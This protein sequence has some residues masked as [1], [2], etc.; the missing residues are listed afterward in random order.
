MEFFG[1]V[2][3]GYLLSLDVG[4]QVIGY[5]PYYIAPDELYELHLGHYRVPLADI[6]LRLIRLM[7]TSQPHGV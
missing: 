3:I 7:W 2:G 1:L 4:P 5:L 6:T